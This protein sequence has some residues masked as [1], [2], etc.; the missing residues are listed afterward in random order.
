MQLN[1]THRAFNTWMQD[2]TYSI[3]WS[4]FAGCIW[5]CCGFSMFF[6]LFFFTAAAR[7]SDKSDLHRVE[8]VDTPLRWDIPTQTPL[9]DGPLCC[10]CVPHTSGVSGKPCLSVLWLLTSALV[11]RWLTPWRAVWVSSPASGRS[12][13]SGRQAPQKK[14]CII[15]RRSL[16]VIRGRLL[17]WIF[18]F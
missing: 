14:W 3:K 7:K 6:C 4:S 13:R 10:C 11:P 9:I 12:W 5:A 15:R 8:G 16:Q 18:L 17:I 1:I 2:L